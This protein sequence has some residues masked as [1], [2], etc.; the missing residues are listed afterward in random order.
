MPVNRLMR[1]IKTGDIH[2]CGEQ[3]P[4]LLKCFASWSERADYFGTSIGVT[5]PCNDGLSCRGNLGL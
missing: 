5:W 2:A 1:K 4:N 3:G